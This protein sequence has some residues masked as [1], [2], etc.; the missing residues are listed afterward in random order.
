MVDFVSWTGRAPST[1][2]GQTGED[3]PSETA[4]LD[5]LI[6]S[7]QIPT[8]SKHSGLPRPPLRREITRV[9][10]EHPFSE[11][12][13][14]CSVFSLDFSED[15][16]LLAAGTRLGEVIVY[17]TTS[18]LVDYHFPTNTE[19]CPITA[20]RFRPDSGGRKNLLAVCC[21]DGSIQYWH[22]TSS[23]CLAKI[24]LSDNC[25]LACDY[26]GDGELL[27]I[28]GQDCAVRV[29]DS[30]HQLVHTLK[31]GILSDETSP[32]HSGRVCSVRFHNTDHNILVSGGWDRSLHVWDLRVERS[33]RSIYGPYICGQALDLRGDVVLSG[34]T[35]DRH[36]MQLWHLGS[37][38]LMMDIPLP[39]AEASVWTCQ[40][41]CSTSGEVIVG[42][43][44]GLGAVLKISGAPE[45]VVTAESNG[46]HTTYASACS[47]SGMVAFAGTPGSVVGYETELNL[48][49]KKT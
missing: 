6:G 47:R 17:N 37:C 22:V 8:S 30:R 1:D 41:T 5:S 45:T 18:G 31:S 20:L 46:L 32:G 14:G 12:P 39:V 4:Y 36:Q 13:D 10:R 7:L 16:H 29:F 27:A 2:P 48:D 11:V 3:D 23:R 33:V 40:F 28:G 44:H 15:E 24:T 38:K 43:T 49:S 19:R 9:P 35:A 26:R 21:A 34:A 25:A 42:G